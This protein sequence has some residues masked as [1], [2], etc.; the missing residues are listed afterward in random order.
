MEANYKIICKF[1]KYFI[2]LDSKRL[3][4]GKELNSCYISI[5]TIFK[6]KQTL[7]KY[8]TPINKM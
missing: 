1:W 2:A 7:N 3:F 8:E 5:F 4:V 6:R